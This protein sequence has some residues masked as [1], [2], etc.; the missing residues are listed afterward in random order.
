MALIIILIVVA[1]AAAL[2]FGL[3]NT[4]VLVML[5]MSLVVLSGA[6]SQL[7]IWR[8]QKEAAKRREVAA[9]EWVSTTFARQVNQII[10]TV[11]NENLVFANRQ[12][13]EFYRLVRELQVLIQ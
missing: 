3:S 5:L 4:K 13:F 8:K 2:K 9:N 1:I 11:C 10:N 12:Y 7:F 6:I